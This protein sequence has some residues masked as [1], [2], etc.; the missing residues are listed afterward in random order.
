MPRPP[1]AGSWPE[2]REAGVAVAVRVTPKSA[3]SGLGGFEQDAGGRLYLKIKVTQPPDKGKA[4]QAALKL[5]S[6][7]WGVPR[8]S[9]TIASGDKDRNKIIVAAGDQDT[10]MAMLWAWRKAFDEQRSGERT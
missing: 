9:L 7:A 5:L 1:P 4:N 6:K 10:L 8:S 2:L 3:A